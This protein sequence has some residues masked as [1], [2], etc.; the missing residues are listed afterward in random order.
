LAISTR[1]L[2]TQNVKTQKINSLIQLCQLGVLTKKQVA[3]QLTTEKI[4]LF[5]PEEIDAIPEDYSIEDM[6]NIVEVEDVSNSLNSKK[7][8]KFYEFWKK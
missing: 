3:E 6:E 1:V 5:K 7:K 4:I 8:K 2:T